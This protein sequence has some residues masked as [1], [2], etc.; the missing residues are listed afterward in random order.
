MMFTYV[1]CFLGAG[2]VSGQELWQ[3]FGSYGKIGIPGLFLAIFL[4]IVASVITMFL[5]YDTGLFGMDDI[6]V[7]GDRPILKKIF[8]YFGVFLFFSIGSIMTAGIGNLT[9]SLAGLPEW[10]GALVVT[11]LASVVA[12]KGLE[13]MVAVFSYT[14]PVLIVVAVIICIVRLSGHANAVDL[15]GGTVNPMLG[16]WPVSAVNYM[17]MN[18]FGSIALLS[19]LARHVKGGKKSI[20]VAITGGSLVLLFVALLIVL[21][22]TTAEG[23]VEAEMPMLVVAKAVGSVAS[24]VYGILIFLAMFGVAQSSFVAVISH[25]E[26]EFEYIKKHRLIFII[27]IGILTFLASLGGFSGLISIVYPVFGYVGIL[28]VIFVVIHYIFRKKEMKND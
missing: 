19:P 12:Y 28:S 4:L 13:G 14:S 5:A 21:S 25:L 18:I 22:L 9:L 27:I 7:M 15:S 23:A 3:Y 10:T 24:W 16:P 26:C 2:Y 11:I 20:A 6:I 17:A 1:G 8:G